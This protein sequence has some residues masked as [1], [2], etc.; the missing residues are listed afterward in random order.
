MKQNIGNS[1]KWNYT[2]SITA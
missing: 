2:I 1:E